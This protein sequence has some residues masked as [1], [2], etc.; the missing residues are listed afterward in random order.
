MKELI[1]TALV[2][3]LLDIVSGVT[4]AC[5]NKERRSSAMREGR[6]HKAAE[7]ILIAVGAA[8]QYAISM[9]ELNGM[10]PDA[11]FNS[12]SVYVIL[13][14]LVSI[15]ENVSKVNPDLKIGTLLSMFGKK[16]Q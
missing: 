8:S 6:Y 16:E 14:E 1:I 2:F 10:I 11:I 12:V 3:I 15:L 7:I 13:M 9:T 4:A 5:K